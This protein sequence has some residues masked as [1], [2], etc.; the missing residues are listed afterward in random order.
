[1]IDPREVA[2]HFM[3]LYSFK[4]VKVD[5]LTQFHRDVTLITVEIPNEVIEQALEE[6]KKLIEQAREQIR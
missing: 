5:N 6:R 1:M 3:T 4:V 2:A